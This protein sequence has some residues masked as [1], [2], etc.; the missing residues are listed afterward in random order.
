MATRVTITPGSPPPP[1]RTNYPSRRRGAWAVLFAFLALVVIAAVA[2]VLTLWSGVTLSTDPTAL[3]R[4]DTQPFAGSL[5]SAV[6]HGPDG[7]TIPLS[8][9]D[10]RLTPLAPVRAGELISVDVTVR[11]PGIVAW[12]LGSTRTEHLTVRA[13]VAHV[14]S[15]WLT[16][17]AGT[18]VRVSFDQPVR[19]VAYGAA[20]HLVRQALAGPQRD[21]TVIG[22][23]AAGSIQIAAAVRPWEQLGAPVNVSWFPPPAPGASAVALVRPAPGSRIA[24]DATIRLTLSRPVAAVF[25]SSVP[26]LEPAIAGTWRQT[27]A[28]TLV[29]TPTGLGAPLYS[30]VR[31]VLPRAVTLATAAGVSSVAQTE[32]SWTTPPASMLRLQQL[33]AQQGYL[34][35]TWQPAGAA[36]PRTASAQLAAAARAPRG[37][38]HWRYANTPPQLE[39]LWSAGHANMI[40]R[41][42]VMMFE[43]EHGLAS[44]GIAGPLVWHALLVDAVAG[45]RHAAAYSYVL[46]HTQLPQRLELWSAGH[47]VLTSPGNTG[48]P[49]RPTKPG[50]FP[51]FEHIPVGTMSGTNPD[52]S[53]YHD[54]GIRWISY[55][56]GG[57]A[58]HEFP[59]ATFGTP[60]SLGCVDLPAAAAAKVYPYTPI[61]TLVTIENA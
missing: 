8:V 14:V 19:A 56:N 46:V 12:A 55:F 33:L 15:R 18:P 44:D 10:G 21:V 41:G 38:F 52:G 39:R 27:G 29:F 5:E 2:L 34:P 43:H 60:Q 28:H 54:P 37:H 31:L 48:I 24:P 6:A 26:K 9:A 45:R 40:V 30:G 32:I 16:V 61:G 13:P 50:T 11:R 35:L 25:G 49:S 20:G 23:A 7:R 51:V 17:P 1:R 22:Q 36:I 47:V 57:D 42:A 3:A 59:R 4:L 53:H 58:L